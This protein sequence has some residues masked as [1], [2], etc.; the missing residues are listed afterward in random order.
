MKKQQLTM[1]QIHEYF[2]TG[3]NI[4]LPHKSGNL[5]KVIG[6]FT[7]I[8]KG[9]IFKFNDGTELDCAITHY[10]E[11]DNNFTNVVYL[12]IGDNI[13]DKIIIDIIYTD[14]KEYLDIEVDS[15]DSTYI[16]NRI[17]HHNS[18]K[19]VTIALIADFL[20]TKGKKGL[21]IVPNIS[22]VQQ[23]H[24]DFKDYKLQDLAD[25]C[26]LIGGSNNIKNLDSRVSISTRQSL[27]L[28]DKNLFKDI[29][30]V[31]GDEVHGSRGSQ[32]ADILRNCTN[33]KYKIGLTGTL[34]DNSIEKMEIFS[35]LGIPK[36]Y[37][38]TQDLINICLATPVKIN[39]I[40]LKYSPEFTEMMKRAVNYAARLVLLKEHSNRSEF[41]A[42]LSVKVTEQSG[43]SIVLFQHTEHGKELYRKI[44]RTKTGIDI[45]DKNITGKH[46]L[47]YQKQH[48]C[49]FINGEVKD[50]VREEIR[51]ILEKDKKAILVGN[52]AI[53]GTGINIK[54]I[55]NIIFGSPLKSFITVTQSLGRGIRLHP[56]KEVVNIYDIAEDLSWFKSQ[57]NYRIKASYEPEGFP[58]FQSSM[59]V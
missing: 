27:A 44:F 17:V 33:A 8:S 12:K 24:S 56:D 23:I 4:W 3:K 38:R 22:L 28:M 31:I 10:I 55:H 7:K 40:N 45:E 57:L 49:Y 53:L 20:R 35:Q 41:I 1:K 13:G 58:I 18:G 43:N 9:I 5:T 21:I 50:T 6:L 48:Q 29:D 15:E 25:N 54:Q 39:I 16:Q 32:Y 2:N 47:E 34:P 26:H 36:V 19:S 59:L 46:A 30:F 37:I 51:Q 14:E 11:I 52:V 42:S